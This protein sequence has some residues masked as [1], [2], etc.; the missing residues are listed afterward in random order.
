[1]ASLTFNLTKF[2]K[3]SIAGDQR[4]KMGLCITKTNSVCIRHKPKLTQNNL[5]GSAKAARAKNK[6]NYL[7]KYYANTQAGRSQHENVTSKE[8]LGALSRGSTG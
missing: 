1:M 2:E 7:C 8:L 5:A 6:F 3:T 4:K